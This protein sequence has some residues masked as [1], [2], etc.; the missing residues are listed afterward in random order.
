MVNEKILKDKWKLVIGFI[1]V[2]IGV[3][4]IILTP[5]SYGI[6]SEEV[7]GVLVSYCG[8]ILGGFLMLYGVWLTIENNKKDK[9]EEISVQYLPI[10]Q[11]KYKK[12]RLVPEKIEYTEYDFDDISEEA[13]IV[14]INHYM[15]NELIC[16]IDVKNTGRGEIINGQIS[17]LSKDSIIS[18]DYKMDITDIYPQ[19]SFKINLRIDINDFE[20]LQEIEYYKEINVEIRFNDIMD[21]EYLS[22]IP[23]YIENHKPYEYYDESKEEVVTNWLGVSYGIRKLKRRI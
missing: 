8:A 18:I 7:G 19:D 1:I 12:I 15:V 9:R 3:P 6:F 22:I 5:S 20:Q 11:V 10:L 13:K 17:C 2:S 23:I 21:K 14:N 16:D 4:I